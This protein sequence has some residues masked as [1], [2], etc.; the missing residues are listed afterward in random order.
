MSAAVRP[1]ADSTLTYRTFV[2]SKSQNDDRRAAALRGASLAFQQR[3]ITETTTS[4]NAQ[5]G[6]NAALAAAT[7]VG[8]PK[9][10]PHVQVS[11][12]LAAATKVGTGQLGTGNARSHRHLSRPLSAQDGGKSPTQEKL[13]ALE[14][15]RGAGTTLTTPQRRKRSS[16]M[17]SDM[18]NISTKSYSGIA[19]TLAAARATP[20][21]PSTN[22]SVRM[23]RPRQNTFNDESP[24]PSTRSLVNAFEGRSSRT[25]ARS[26]D[27]WSQQP[28][29]DRLSTIASPKPVR[30]H[31]SGKPSLEY[32]ITPQSRAPSRATLDGTTSGGRNLFAQRHNTPG[33]VTEISSP[34]FSGSQLLNSQSSRR[35][36]QASSPRAME[37]P[38]PSPSR[39]SNKAMEFSIR[40]PPRL[41]PPRNANT[42]APSTAALDSDSDRPIKPPDSTPFPS[43]HDSVP[44][45]TSV[46]RTP[47]PSSSESS[48]DWQDAQ[49]H[50]P[51]SPSPPPKPKVHRAA[52]IS[53]PQSRSQPSWPPSSLSRTGRAPALE[54]AKLIDSMANAI[55]AS[56]LASSRAPSRMTSPL[57]PPSNPPLQQRRHSRSHFFFSAP[58]PIPSRTP[59]PPKQTNLR[60]TLRTERPRSSDSDSRTSPKRRGRK[61]LVRRHHKKHHEGARK[62][63]RDEITE[64]E[65]KRYEGVWAA[66]KGLLVPSSPDLRLTSA[67]TDPA[68]LVQNLVVADIW[69]R[70]R[71]PP[72]ILEEIWELVNRQ[73]AHY[74]TRDEFVVGLWLVDQC[75][76]GRKL[77][78]RV[79][80]S[81]WGSVRLLRG[82]NIHTYHHKHG[83]DK[84]KGKV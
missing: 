48:S 29:P 45:R 75:L 14:E 84:G 18:S 69:T 34:H 42:T 16:T 67:S 66:N 11:P 35:S 51:R 55:V 61:H 83:K 2:D 41:P 81:V 52:P 64:R 53:R 36:K 77:P 19:A 30:P 38:S 37:S 24:I 63:W 59:S 47:S 25:G 22:A 21:S 17:L 44:V 70:S 31:S 82:V 56:S 7:K 28:T 5:N 65:R 73:E 8:S 50:F 27:T 46:D 26:P 68:T 80:E 40:N 79:S 54:K 4:P 1:R 13:R 20:T 71:L 62:R 78:I 60:T 33:A 57:P 72:D 6:I 15:L 10:N 39:V 74:L 49:T 58:T 23:G 9:A 3:P 43:F 76:K 12:A 32:V